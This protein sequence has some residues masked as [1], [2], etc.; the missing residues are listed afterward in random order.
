M[1]THVYQIRNKIIIEDTSNFDTSNF[2]FFILNKFIFV[3]NW[4]KVSRGGSMTDL[5]L[6]IDLNPNFGKTDLI[7]EESFLTLQGGPERMQQ[8]W[9][10][11]SW[12]SPMKQNCFL[13]YL[14]EHLFSNKMTPWSLVL[15]KVSGL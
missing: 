4:Q 13:F 14:V 2:E 9:L 12:T 15:G 6:N 8:L 5:V 10:L 3:I 1:I 11:I 7:M